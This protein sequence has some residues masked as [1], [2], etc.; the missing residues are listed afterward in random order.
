MLEKY[1][2]V[3][4]TILSSTVGLYII[5]IMFFEHQINILE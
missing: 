4:T 3:F 5:I 1:I 2:M